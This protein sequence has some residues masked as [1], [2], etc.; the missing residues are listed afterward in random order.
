MMTANVEYEVIREIGPVEIRRYPSL[1]LATVFAASD[2]E[3]FS[4]LFDYISGSNDPNQRIAM[5]APVISK[6]PAGK[7]IAMTA[8]VISN[9]GS[10]SFV[11]PS[12]YDLQTAPRPIDQRIRLEH[13]PPRS[14]AVIK[15]TGRAHEHDVKDEERILLD[16]LEENKV[17]SNGEPF[18]MRYNGPFTPGFMRHNEL[19]IEVVKDDRP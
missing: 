18:L 3:A 2:N 7:K 10:F 14:V 6:G 13:V 9:E 1:T 19:G 11:L 4:I 16:T 15:F 5:T 12:G 8:P 17:R